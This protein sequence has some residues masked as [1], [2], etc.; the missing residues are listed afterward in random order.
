[1]IVTKCSTERKGHRSTNLSRCWSDNNAASGAVFCWL[2]K[3]HYFFLKRRTTNHIFTRLIRSFE[4]QQTSRQSDVDARRPHRSSLP[5]K[6]IYPS[7]N[8]LRTRLRSKRGVR[9]CGT[10]C[11]LC[12]LLKGWQMARRLFVAT[13]CS[14]IRCTSVNALKDVVR[15]I[16][17]LKC[18]VSN[19]VQTQRTPRVCSWLRSVYLITCCLNSW[20]RVRKVSASK[21]RTIWPPD[22]S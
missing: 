5:K 13:S 8:N 18:W 9:S 22:I 16:S 2:S 11:P 20:E 19:N 1:M 21:P 14:H 3:N 7:N 17:A 15:R 4:F 12:A 6:K 10:K